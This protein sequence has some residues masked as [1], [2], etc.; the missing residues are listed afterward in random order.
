M[1]QVGLYEAKTS[2]SSLVAEVESTGKAIALTKHGKVVAGLSPPTVAAPKAGMLVAKAR[3]RGLPI[4]S[5]DPQLDAHGV[6]RIG[7]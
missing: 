5:T 6:E 7:T 3:R 1:K 2:L 4:L